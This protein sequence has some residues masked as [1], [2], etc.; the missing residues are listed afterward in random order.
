MVP[1]LVI[2]PIPETVRLVFGVTATVGEIAYVSVP[3]V[4]TLLVYEEGTD[5]ACIA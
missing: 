4:R 3:M 5:E 2:V 1:T